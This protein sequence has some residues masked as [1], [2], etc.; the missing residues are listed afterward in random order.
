MADE[1][2]ANGPGRSVEAHSYRISVLAPK[3]IGEGEAWLTLVQ[4]TTYYEVIRAG[5]ALRASMLE[6]GFDADRVRAWFEQW[7][8]CTEY[9]TVITKEREL[10]FNG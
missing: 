4:P 3:Q 6:F 7:V 1:N 8:R 10:P 5:A 2:D 9:K